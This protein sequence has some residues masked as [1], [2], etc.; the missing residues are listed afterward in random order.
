MNGL[1]MAVG[2]VGMALFI[3]GMTG[4]LVSVLAIL[5]SSF[6]IARNG[7]AGLLL[8]DFRFI[9][10]SKHPSTVKPHVSST[11]R[12]A[13]WAALGFV[14]VGLGQLLMGLTGVSLPG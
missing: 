1:R 9:D 7:G 8:N 3:V 5:G 6:Q 11:W 13:G 14:L 2:Y 10:R 4:F 12:W